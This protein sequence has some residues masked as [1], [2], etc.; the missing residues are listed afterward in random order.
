MPAP[1]AFMKRP[2]PS[3]VTPEEPPMLV[4][5]RKPKVP[6]VD[7]HV[8][9]KPEFAASPLMTRFPA[10][11]RRKVPLPL[12]ALVMP[13]G[14]PEVV[15]AASKVAPDEM[16]REVPVML[17]RGEFEPVEPVIFKVPPVTAM[18]RRPSAPEVR[19]A[20]LETVRVPFP[21]LVR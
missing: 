19:A 9:E 11:L 20:L 8:P 4:S 2:P 15:F 13:V 1:L 12:M 18:S 3:R 6:A 21:D 7:F 17:L 10:A 16:A 5:E 14:M